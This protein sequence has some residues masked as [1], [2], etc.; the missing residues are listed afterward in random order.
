MKLQAIL[1]GVAVLSL[2]DQAGHAASLT[3]VDSGVPAATIVLAER[4]TVPARLAV[5][6]LQ[7]HVKLITGAELPV[8]T[9]TTPVQGT[10]ILVG[11]SAATRELGLTSD[12]FEPQEYVVQ[13]AP[14]TLVLMGR[15][16]DE[17]ARGNVSVYGRPVPAE[18]MFGRALSFDGGSAIGVENC[19][20]NDQEGSMEAWVFLPEEL[21]ARAGTILRLD[22]PGPWT[23][24]ILQREPNS[25]R[26]S[27]V[28]YDGNRGTA[29]RTGELSPGWHHLLATHSVANDR[30][31]LFV[32]GTSAGSAKY[33]V[34][35]CEGSML[36]VGATGLT[37]NMGNP[38]TGRIDAVRVTR[39]VIT[40]EE[41]GFKAR[42][43]PG[44]RTATLLH[45]DEESGVP[46]DSGGRLGP[47]PIPDLH[48]DQATCYA[49]YD[50]LERFCGVRWFNP[51]D[52]GTVYTPRETLT[53]TGESIRRSPVFKMRTGTMMNPGNY[54]PSITT[55][56]QS[57]T[58]EFAEFEATAYARLHERAANDGAFRAAKN[59]QT[60]LFLHRMRVGGER[61]Y[62]NH[63]L[64][65]YYDR[66]WR[67]GE[68]KS[69]LFVEKR[70]A[71]FAK[72]Y[73]GEPPQMCYTDEGFLE[74]LAQD[75]RNYYDGKVTGGQ[76]GI[77]WNPIPPNMFPVEPM[78]NAA[79]CKCEACQEWVSQRE[80]ASVFFSNGRDSDYFFN[81]INGV[82]RKLRETHP[83]KWVITLAYMSHAAPPEKV[84]L[85]PNVAVQYCFACNRLNYDRPSYEHELEYL[86][87]WGEESKRRPMYLW[88]YDTFP[89]E[90]AVNGKFHC[91]PGYFAH[92]VGEQFKLFHEYGYR[93]IF[94]CGYGQEI[95]AYLTYKL[96]DDPTLDVDTLLDE[97]FTGMYGPA[98]EPMKRI[99]LEIEQ[100]Y[101]DPKSYPP[102][103]AEGRMEGH[104]HQT[105]EIAWGWLGTQERMDRWQGYLDQAKALAPTGDEAARIAVF[106]KGIW[107]YMLAGRRKYSTRE[108][109]RSV[110]PP[111]GEAPKVSPAN[112]DPTVID[113][114]QVGNISPF[115]QNTGEPTP[116]KVSGQV[117]H[118]GEWL[119][120][121]LTEEG[122]L[123]GLQASPRIYDGDD[124]EIF[125]STSRGGATYYQVGVNPSGVWESGQYEAPRK[126][127]P[128]KTGLRVTSAITEAKDRWTVLV[129]VPLKEIAPSGLPNGGS[130]FLNV[131]RGGPHEALAWS[132]TAEH[133]FHMP[134]RLGEVVLK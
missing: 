80:A 27:Y 61:N 24:H 134:D 4:P 20:F 7:T 56:W 43:A 75:A 35:C 78:D 82:A 88:L 73:N 48:D 15:D 100:V 17:P 128:W 92:T 46:V 12:D 133:N 94:H 44:P 22:S 58:P 47:A 59:R 77:F 131:F 121:R 69:P 85:E 42:P 53:V 18:G 21:D 1:I 84:A 110:P 79:F 70:P 83:D 127:E 8:V 111:L 6:E 10:R 129:A 122:D 116:R 38:F 30:F 130:V 49:V 3:L 114:A 14:D 107:N 37:G 2:T 119:Y 117:A 55:F 32:D 11:E 54:D 33:P 86:A 104:H 13:F 52:F 124:W 113:W 62:C 16:S 40:P 87:Q 68:N 25:R 31:E 93:G 57:G 36:Q 50:F 41:S 64:Y 99:Y 5:E 102:A 28:I 112:G 89:W 74:Q 63:S 125:L 72:G 126:G 115:R 45:F 91:F 105:E 65:G 132:P 29:V 39:A 66:F 108:Q 81:F 90:V 118:D 9:D 26:I 76:L 60:S 98:A 96:M 19:A 120:L 67:D 51:T 123:K 106:E 103:I 23:Y 109:Y 71:Y 95:E 34:T 97:Y 101:G